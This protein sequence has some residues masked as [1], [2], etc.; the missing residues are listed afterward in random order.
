MNAW[1]ESNGDNLGY[2]DAGSGISAVFLHPTPLNRDYWRPLI[3]GFAGV[4]AI[5]P[6]LRGHGESELGELLPYG[7]F[8]RAPHTPVLTMTQLAADMLA[9]LDHLEISEA[10][11]VGC[12]I[13]G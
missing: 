3:A 13:G 11:F 7:L 1:F 5:V 8:S 2:R 12:S 6:D 10:A 9:L 4:R